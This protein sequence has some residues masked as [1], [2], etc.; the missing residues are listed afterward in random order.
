MHGLTGEFSQ[1]FGSMLSVKG[2]G[3]LAWAGDDN[4]IVEDKLT[5]Q[6]EVI[7]ILYVIVFF[8]PSVYTF[9]E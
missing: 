9:S 5:A 8:S 7:K 1:A 6:P 4:F 3:I 2:E